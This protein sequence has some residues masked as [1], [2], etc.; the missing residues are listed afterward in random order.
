[1]K[2]PSFD[3]DRHFS[4]ASFNLIRSLAPELSKR[5]LPSSFSPDRNQYYISPFDDVVRTDDIE[6]L[7]AQLSRL[8][9]DFHSC[10]DDDYSRRYL[11]HVDFAQICLMLLDLE[12]PDNDY[13]LPDKVLISRN[14]RQEENV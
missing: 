4:D 9:E 10:R 11:V 2:S 6:A 14:Y 7:K 8:G 1:M 12:G 3:W 13:G 5:R